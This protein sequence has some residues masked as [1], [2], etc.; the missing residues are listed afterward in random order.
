MIH[1]PYNFISLN[2]V[3]YTPEWAKLISQDIPFSD[4][5]SGS[6]ELKIKAQTPI[7]VRNGH[8]GDLSLADREENEEY[9]SFSKTADNRYFIPGTSIKGAIRNILEIMS[10]GKMRL[11]KQRKFAQ[12]E[13]NNES[14]YNIK[15]N[16]NK[17][18]CGWLK[19][20]PRK[21]YYIVDCGKPYRIGH[22][23]LDEYIFSQTQKKDLF[24]FYFRNLEEGNNGSNDDMT[25]LNQI[26]EGRESKNYIF[27][28]EFLLDGRK[29]DPKTATFKYALVDGLRLD[30]L[31]FVLDENK[32][33]KGTN[34]KVM[35][36][37]E[38]NGD[39]KGSIVFTGQPNQWILPRPKQLNPNA[40]KFYDFVFKKPETS[41][42]KDGKEILPPSIKLTDE[43][44]NNYQ[45]IY[46]DSP[47]WL[48]WVSKVSTTGI[49]VF[50]WKED[51]E[52]KMKWGLAMLFK[53]PYD[54]TPYETLPDNHKPDKE[55][56]ENFDLADCIFGT[57]NGNR[58]LK[59]RVSFGHA[60]CTNEDPQQADYVRLILSSPKASYYPCYIAQSRTNGK[61]NTYNDGRIS[62]WKRYIVRTS[63]GDLP[64]LP[65]DVSENTY[66]TLYP[67]E[68]GTEFTSVVRFHNLRPVELGALLSALTFHNHPECFHQLGQGKPFGYGKVKID[69]VL[70]I[71]DNRYKKFEKEVFMA[72]FESVLPNSQVRSNDL[73]AMASNSDSNRDYSYMKLSVNP[74]INEF[75]EAKTKNEY[76]QPFDVGNKEI[77]SVLVSD[78]IRNKLLE[79]DD[80]NKEV[81]DGLQKEIERRKEEEKKRIFAQK[82]QMEAKNLFCQ[83]RI[84]EA[85]R[86]YQ[87]AYD[88]D[89]DE[90]ILVELGK[91]DAAKQKLII[92][93]RDYL[94]L[95]SSVSS[96]PAFAN[97][98]RKWV[99]QN[100]KSDL[101]EEEIK[102][103]IDFLKKVY[104]QLS[105]KE[106]KI[107]NSK[108]NWDNLH[109]LIN[110]EICTSVIADT[111]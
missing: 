77:G 70:Q 26:A 9:K 107:W 41:F 65:A 25:K 13:W 102:Q 48:Y 11:D 67:L 45:S 38:G 34:K 85:R 6:I 92:P 61:L 57:T 31:C 56:N 39:F 97:R 21:G 24:E 69:S 3:V 29:Y 104:S 17:I 1:A 53:L 109:K 96:L 89:P 72:K 87:E 66:T 63:V 52:K 59:G 28:N 23:R 36:C 44:F 91:C 60:F 40:G 8:N 83:N 4:G 84:E 110:Q 79:L 15:K 108:K 93:L 64:E 32:S 100:G 27:E 68:S 14:L 106:R 76:L 18:K 58:L 90:S 111:K 42:D 47:D 55:G 99:E 75:Q 54:K 37:A 86:K 20:E 50:F 7:F 22:N 74:A 19:W 16:Q 43:E 88:I 105:K 103:I 35:V 98:L 94:H 5:I 82:L 49:P 33:Q 2:E 30:D 101:N 12:R 71:A 10:Y 81:K 73:I 95:C 80:V 51:K 78:I 46:K 62:G